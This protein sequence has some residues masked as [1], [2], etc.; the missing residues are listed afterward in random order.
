MKL[1]IVESPNKIKKLELILGS[2]WKVMASVGHIR[3]LPKSDLGIEQDFSLVYEF[4]PAVSIQGRTFPSGSERV[5]R[6]KQA[7][8]SASMVYLASDPDR[9]GEAIAWHLKETMGL[10]ESEYHRITFDAITPDV[11]KA[12]L[13]KPRKIDYE[14]VHAQEARR[15]LDRMF[16]YLVSPILS[17]LLGQSLSAGRVQSPAVRIVVDRERQIQQFKK[18]SHF[19][20]SVSFDNQAWQAVWDTKKHITEEAPYVVEEALASKAA[21]CRQF[22]VIKA[23]TGISKRSPPPPFSTSLLLQAAS[24]SLKLDP[25]VTAKVAQKLF[26]Q[27]LITYIRTDGVNFSDEAVASI[28]AFAS[29]KGYELPDKPRQ[30]KAKGDAQEAHEAIRPTNIE[31]ESAGEDSTQ[32]ALYRMIWQRSVA[33]QLAD[34]E[35]KTNSIT[36][37]STDSAERFE[38]KAKSRLLIKQGWKALTAQDLTQENDEDSD[39]LGDC[40]NVP[41]LA[42]NARTV[43]ES[44]KV[45]S[46]ETKPPARFTKASL[47]AKLE[48]EGIGR[49]STYPAIMQNITAK[50]YLTEVKRFLQPSDV[51][52]A[53]VDQLI[54]AEFSFIQLSFTRNL[55]SQLDIIA[56]GE[57]TYLSV[58]EAAYTQLQADIGHAK[59]N[60]SAK[61]LFSCPKCGTGALRRYAKKDKSGFGWFCTSEACKTFLD[62]EKGKPS[63]PLIHQCPTCKTA[64]LRRYQKKDKQT[65]KPNGFGW[66][67]TSENCKTFLEDNKGKPFQIKTAPCPNCGKPMIRRKNE[68]GFWWGCTGFKEGCKVVMNDEKG[69]PSFKK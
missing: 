48:A 60:G 52:C 4:I 39:E 17:N 31:I 15:A 1:M 14:L 59:T 10:K 54:K 69:K 46:K 47:I 56:A 18:T 41:A 20:A 38:F 50:G 45:I 29:T 24:V 55:E 30:F 40:G 22:G 8:K 35:Y 53:L 58:V 12:A 27:G 49:P 64:P 23:D 42:E 16:G 57:C 5:A 51:G 32:I 62:D 61:P 43:A 65:G 3:D 44:G 26:E 7:A 2:D 67:C 36:L 28:R 6:I 66:F 11:I 25:E 33:S 9:E 13:S 37:E 19:G 34:A 63:T 21:A 68:R